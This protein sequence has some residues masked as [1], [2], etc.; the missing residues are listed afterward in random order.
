MMGRIIRSGE[1]VGFVF[2]PEMSCQTSRRE[3]VG[4]VNEFSPLELLRIEARY[5]FSSLKCHAKYLKLMALSAIFVEGNHYSN[6]LKRFS[7][8]FLNPPECAYFISSIIASL[9]ML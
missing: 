4:W 3:V 7:T 5:L 2:F 9:L 8:L 1:Y 6:K